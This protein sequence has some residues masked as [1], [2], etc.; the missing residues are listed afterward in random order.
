MASRVSRKASLAKLSPTTVTISI[1]TARVA[2]QALNKFVGGDGRTKVIIGSAEIE[3]E[4]VLAAVNVTEEASP[5][6][7]AEPVSGTE[8]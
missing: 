2:Q 7:V 3:L 5:N 8:V 6:G 1:Q 4:Q